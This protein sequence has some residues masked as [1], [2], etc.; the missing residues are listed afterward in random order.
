MKE[1]KCFDCKRKRYT[2]LNYPK[3]AKISVITDASDVD[4]IENIDIEKK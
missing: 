2:M 4:N 3:K 1:G